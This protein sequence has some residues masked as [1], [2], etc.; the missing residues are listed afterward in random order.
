[1]ETDILI[2]HSIQ[3]FYKSIDIW[4][5]ES[6]EFDCHRYE[7]SMNKVKRK[8]LPYRN[9][10]YQISLFKF[11]VQDIKV[12]SKSYT[13]DEGT[14]FF[15]ASGNVQSWEI[16]DDLEG[17]VMFFSSTFLS[18]SIVN[19]RI[20]EN[21]PFFGV[22]SNISIKLNGEQFAKLSSIYNEILEELSGNYFGK[23]EIIRSLLLLIMH[24]SSRIY[25]SKD[26]SEP[27]IADSQRYIV[28]KFQALLSQHYEQLYLGREVSLKIASDYASELFIHPNYLNQVTKKV[29]GKTAS[30]LIKEKTI[31]EAKVLLYQTDFSISE[32]AYKLGFETNTYFSRFF[33]K[34]TGKTP[35]EYKNSPNL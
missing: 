23:W 30:S 1:M 28:K 12:N 16:V 27:D 24:Q 35:S 8:M 6:S 33:K 20:L 31:H 21:F 9:M 29:L 4:E 2:F 13:M 10:F 18:S 19:S 32:I 11:G 26:E 3:D 15:S 17:F 14:L 7:L 34:E 5:P 25:Y 22:D